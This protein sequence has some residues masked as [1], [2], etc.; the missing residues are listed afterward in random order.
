M[1]EAIWKLQ[2]NPMTGQNDIA[3]R[4][5]PDGSQESCTITNP[6]FQSDLANGASLQ[7]SDGTDMTSK[8]IK[9]F[10]GTLA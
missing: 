1:N 2:K 7:D 4:Q 10:L 5:W 3:W 6:S 9:T 8:Q